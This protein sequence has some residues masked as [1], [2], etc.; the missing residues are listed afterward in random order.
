MFK[1]IWTPAGNRYRVENE[2]QKR[3]AKS[4]QIWFSAF[5]S[6]TELEGSD[7]LTHSFYFSLANLQIKTGYHYAKNIIKVPTRAQNPIFVSAVFPCG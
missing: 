3:L 6:P 1:Y 7:R 5:S 2:R 4:K